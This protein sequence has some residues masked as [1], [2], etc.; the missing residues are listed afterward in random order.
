MYQLGLLAD[1]F[2]AIFSQLDVLLGVVLG[3]VVGLL[4]GA[5]PG[6][7]A[8]VGMVLLIPFS[9]HM[10]PLA[11]ISMLY[12]IHKSGNYGG[13][14]PAILMNTPGSPAAA[15]TQLDGYPLTQQGKQGKALKT[16]VTA[17][18]LGDLASDFV[19][20]FGTVYVAKIVYAFGP[21]EMSG[22][23][24]FSLTLIS[25]ITGN[26]MLKGLFSTALGLLIAT[27]GLDPLQATPRF[28]F[29]ITEMEKSLDVIPVLVG[30]FVV[31]EVL[32]QIERKMSATSMS[33]APQTGN[34][35]D[36]R[37][38]VREFKSILPATGISYVVG[39]VIGV[40]PGLGGA[41]AP[42]IAYGQV[43]SFSKHPEKF[44]KGSLEGVAA[45]EASNNAVCGANLMPMLTLGVPGSTDAAIIMGAFLIHGLELGPNIFTQ[46]TALVYGIFASGL[47]AIAIYFFIGFFLAEK[48][49]RMITKFPRHIIY[50]I[51]MVTCFIGAYAPNSSLFD[52]GIMI[53]FGLIGYIMRKFS[54]PVAP[55]VIA[56]LLA[57]KFETALR[58]SLI[59][60]DNALVFFKHP[61][62]LTFILL[63]VGTVSFT[64]IRDR[65]RDKTVK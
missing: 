30:V 32:V 45:A 57:Y 60:G 5:T 20:I 24:F 34:P 13:S 55:M 59:I 49:G 52:V 22:V 62:C 26:S 64:L 19:L 43:K 51:I 39:Q 18:A 44:G 12:A 21:V 40:L 25:T 56:F 50:P 29:G 46:Q 8:V 11:G 27:I 9:F 3:S 63:A 16:A 1:A 65:K 48:I 23:L 37:L 28:S 58:Q 53:F 47:I 7:T 42:W 41:V 6:L 31:S 38:T 14:I 35:D 36:S 17:S 61:I 54:I 33:V 10:S 15:C 4:L 2:V